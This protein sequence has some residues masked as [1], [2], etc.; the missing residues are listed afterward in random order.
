MPDGAVGRP[1]AVAELDTAGW[2][3]RGIVHRVPVVTRTVPWRTGFGFVFL[4]SCAYDR[5]LMRQPVSWVAN[6]VIALGYGLFRTWF[7]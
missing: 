3:D 7:P 5:W 6:F 2:R 1:D 4:G